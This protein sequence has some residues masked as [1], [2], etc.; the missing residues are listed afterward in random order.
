MRLSLAG[1]EVEALLPHGP[2]MDGTGL[3][4]TVMSYAGSLDIGILACRRAV[5]QV[6]PLADRVAA[7]V[8]ELAGLAE[9]ELGIEQPLLRAVG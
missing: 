7:A 9:L 3:N 1:A 2:V 8:E 5:P 4:I 6:Q